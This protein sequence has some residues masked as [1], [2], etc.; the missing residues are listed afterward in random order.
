MP[1]EAMFVALPHKVDTMLPREAERTL[2]RANL[3]RVEPNR[4][5]SWSRGKGISLGCALSV[6][7]VL[8]R[9]GVSFAAKWR[10][11][12]VSLSYSFINLK[13]YCGIQKVLITITEVYART[14]RSTAARGCRTSMLD[15][16]TVNRRTSLS[17]RTAARGISSQSIPSL[18]H[19]HAVIY[20]KTVVHNSATAQALH[21]TSNIGLIILF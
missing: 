14:H 20:G 12:S 13:R 19:I 16:N 6:E 7:T 18:S 4:S 9:S 17:S 3:A 2:P 10:M 8:W 5:G 11:K 1:R 15:T 21:D